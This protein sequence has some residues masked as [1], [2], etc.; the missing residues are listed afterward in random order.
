MANEPYVRRCDE[1]FGLQEI[2]CCLT[3]NMIHRDAIGRLVSRQE[4]P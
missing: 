1:E 4:P 3:V 2:G